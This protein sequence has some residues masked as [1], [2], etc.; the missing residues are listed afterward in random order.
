MVVQRFCKPKVAGSNPASGT[1]VVDD[2]CYFLRAENF[3]QFFQDNVWGNKSHAWVA[4][5]P[6]GDTEMT[7]VSAMGPVTAQAPAI[8]HSA[9]TQ[10]APAAIAANSP[11]GWFPLNYPHWGNFWQFVDHWQSLIAG[12]LA[13]AAA[14]ITVIGTL[15]AAWWT[16]RATNKAAMAEIAVAQEQIRVSLETEARRIALEAWAFKTALEATMAAVLEGASDARNALGIVPA[17]KMPTTMAYEARQMIPS[18]AFEDIR[19]GCLR[20]G[21]GLTG[22][23]LRLEHQVARFARAYY[24]RTGDTGVQN[25]LGYTDGFFYQV[26]QIEATALRIQKEVAVEIERSR[27]SLAKM[28]PNKNP[29]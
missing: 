6:A 5:C 8:S 26:G 12:S 27:V 10:I 1:I 28:Q 25:H 21:G 9:A 29:A 13:I 11:A 16:N 24:I 17:N 2:L 23:V 15:V 18:G 3:R 19:A 4:C 22:D 7:Q 20:Y 14:I